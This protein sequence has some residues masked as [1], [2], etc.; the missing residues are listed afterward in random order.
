MNIFSKLNA[1]LEGGLS[2]DVFDHVRNYLICAFLL[3]IGTAEFREHSTSLLDI[4]PSQF[5]GVTVIVLSSL[6]I[7]LNLYDAI[8][9]LS[10]SKYNLVLVIILIAL[11]LFFSF[12]VIEMA[13][14][15]RAV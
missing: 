1:A 13:W 10:K 5:H 12:R 9:K 2:K 6:L 4:S 11:Y 7:L 14:E 15:F 8:R 3:A